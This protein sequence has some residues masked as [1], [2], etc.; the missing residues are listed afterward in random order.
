MTA[1]QRSGSNDEPTDKGEQRPGATVDQREVTS[2]SD[3]DGCTYRSVRRGNG[4]RGAAE[5][6]EP[7]RPGRGRKQVP[8]CAHPGRGYAR[9]TAAET[10]DQFSQ[11]V[12]R[13]PRSR[14]FEPH[15]EP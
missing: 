9:D 1:G 4:H 11:A 12:A 6:Q 7:A 14:R 3:R 15:N 13:Q 10:A 2:G 5:Q 8:R